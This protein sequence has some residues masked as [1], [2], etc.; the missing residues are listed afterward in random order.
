[1]LL[2]DGSYNPRLGSSSRLS[3]SGGI[4]TF[5]YKDGTTL[6]FNAN[7]NIASW[8]SPSGTS[9][10]YSYDM[11]TPPLLTSVS[12][13]LGRTLTLNYNGSKQL[14]SV[15][16]NSSPQRS[17]SYSFDT[18][19]NLASFTDPIGNTTTYAYLP[20]AGSS[21]SGLLTQIF[22]PS[23]PSVAA[24]TNT[25]DS[26]NRIQTQA[27]AFGTNWAYYFAGYRS[28][29]DD[30]YGTQHVLYYNPR[31]LTL[32]DIQDYAGLDLQTATLYDGLD[33][34]GTVTLPEGGST[35]YTYATTNPW[36][37][38]VASVTRTPKPG[39]LLSPLTMS[40]TY[41]PTFNK[42]TSI[43]DPLGLVTTMGYDS[44]TGNLLSATA[45]AGTGAHFNATTRFTYTGFGQVGSKTDP[46][47]TITQYAYDSFGNRT[48]TIADAGSGHLNQT[49]SYAYNSTG[50]VTSVTD[51]RG[52]VAT[53]TYDADRRLATTTTPPVAAALG[54]VVTTNSYD[55]D[56]RVLQVQQSA[57]GSVLRTTS[58]T[59]TLTGKP[60]TATDPNAN[61]TRYAYDL[62][63]RLTSTTDA[64]G[65]VTT[66][67][68]DA[69]SRRLS[70]SN[71]AISSTPLAQQSFTPR[72]AARQP[73]RRQQQY[74][75]LRL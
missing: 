61:V 38:N 8:T 66:N 51:P 29:E 26:L 31:G 68:Y 44:S 36:A 12:N 55:P 58:A 15:N 43:T 1:M 22:Y 27:N 57:G 28:E 7:G 37:N 67:V 24:V 5:Q 48:S 18:P 39:S 41:D 19:G 73:D 13:G 69:L 4:Y 14:T 2:A 20:G 71:P 64:A 59:Y 32:F 70:V 46:M 72:W 49:T 56:G 75:E 65:R 34:P 9:V 6:N 45:D 3:L 33:R 17:V 25:Y 52:N 21:P 50:D 62:L 60:A 74:H 35:A 40:Y 42:P 11:S 63:D 10:S 30:P 53:S 23:H 16:D 47:G 54:G